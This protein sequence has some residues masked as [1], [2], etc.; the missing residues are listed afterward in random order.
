MVCDKCVWVWGGLSL[1]CDESQPPLVD[2]APG[3]DL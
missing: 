2:E 1:L 3:R